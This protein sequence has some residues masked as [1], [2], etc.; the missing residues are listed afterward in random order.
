MNFQKIISVCIL[1]LVF[2][3]A[4]AQDWTNSPDSTATIVTFE[5]TRLVDQHTVETLAPRTLDFLI[6]HRFGPINSMAYNAW[7]IDGPANIR[8]ALEYSP[9]SRLMFG[10]GRCSN[11]KM[12][13]G[14]LKFRLLRQSKDTGIPLSLT[15]FAGSY[16]TTMKDG[17]KEAN[18]FD[19]YQYASSRLSY[20]FEVMIARKFSSAFSLQI[21]PWFVHYNL[22]DHITDQ[23][24][25]FGVAGLLRMKFTKRSAITFEYAYRIN[26]YS[27]DVKYYDSMSIGYEVETGGHVFQVHFT[28]SFGLNESQFFAHTDSKWNNMG[29]RLGFNISRKFSL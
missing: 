8:F 17:N 14:F 21:A 25:A 11:E 7:G 23:N 1:A 12:V 5:S 4:K 18:G 10:I 16:Y 2:Y 19:K 3:S 27:L 6:S 13:D 9:T 26:N 29:I 24:D 22:V 15:L 28:N 20:C